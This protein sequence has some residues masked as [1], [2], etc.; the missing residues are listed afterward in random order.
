MNLDITAAVIMCETQSWAFHVL[1]YRL[2]LD[3]GC[4]IFDHADT[5]ESP[6]CFRRFAQI[7]LQ[8]LLYRPIRY[9]SSTTSTRNKLPAGYELGQAKNG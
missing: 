8:P 7:Y 6:P 2:S 9:N 1:L 4:S 3:A 5:I